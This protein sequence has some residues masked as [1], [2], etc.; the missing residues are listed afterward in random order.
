[1]TTKLHNGLEI[2][3]LGMGTYPLQGS[4]MNTAIAAAINSGYRLF[5]T[6]H[7]YGNEKSLGNS[8]HEVFQTTNLKRNDVFI[9]SKI[10]EEIEN[11]IPNCK[12]FYNSFNNEKKNIKAIVSNQLNQTLYDLKTDYLDLLLIHWPHPDY[13]IEI[14]SAMEDEYRGGRVKAIGVSNCRE[15][16]L[17]KIIKDGTI[18][19][20]VNQTEL[21]PLNTKKKLIRFCQNLGIQIQAYSPLLVMNPKLMKVSA[22]KLFSKIHNKS[23]PQLILKWH[24]QQGIIPIPKSGNPIRLTENINIFDFELSEFEMS[25]IDKLNE[26]YKCLIES[27]YCPGY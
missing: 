3:L 16:H 15:W 17:N 8:L 9:I 23:I 25:E 10:G 20:M 24:L 6:A 18:C 22:L 5:D 4:A 21:H 7:A 12:L 11:G 27:K 14:W 26:N 19:P 13:L 1:M 2:P